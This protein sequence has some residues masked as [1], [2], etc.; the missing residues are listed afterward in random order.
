MRKLKLVFWGILVLTL[1][2]WLWA[3]FIS[4]PATSFF[5]RDP[6]LQVTGVLA[7]VCMSVTLALALR[8][9]WPERSLGGLDKMYRLHKWLGIG[10]LVFSLLHWLA[11]S[12]APRGPRGA[13]AGA[14]DASS[15]A[16][17]LRGL[18]D[19]AEGLGNPGLYGVVILIALALLRYFPY[20]WFYKTHRLIGIFYLLLVY[21][22]VVLLDFDDWSKPIG[23]IFALLLL[24]GSWAALVALVGKVGAGR[25]VNGTI[26]ELH[27]Y[28]GVESLEVAV[29]L[30]PGWPGHR[31]G[32]FLFAM[33]SKS[34]G[35]H[36]YTI[37]SPWYPGCTRLV[38]II[39]ALGDHTRRLPEI[40]KTGQAVR[41]EGPYGCFTFD[42]DRPYQIWIGGGI[43]ITPFIARMEHLSLRKDNPDWPA[44]QSIY[45]F[46]S[47]ADVDDEAL[48]KLSAD[49]QAAN[50]Q[51]HI[52][53]DDRDGRLSGAHIREVVPGW[54]D[55]SIW[56]CGPN[57]FGQA[58]RQD[59]AALGFD[60][61]RRFHQELFEMRLGFSR[62]M[63][64]LDRAIHNEMGRINQGPLRR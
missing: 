23:W 17:M 52:L 4:P 12:A 39:R 34:E 48:H 42:D 30:E 55:A 35:A 29:E 9:R 11:E 6:L 27:Y 5:T 24:A 57:G 10:A 63:A 25:Q 46:H 43:G 21:H 26:A 38:G 32:Q 60:V 7:M 8:P 2:L 28:P 22:T 62:V 15:L 59:F 64:R 3:K 13:G 58:I 14:V 61:E 20:R 56:F 45:L 19:G 33:S 1:A 44:G 47:T 49:A 31:P 54:K 18:R 40:L 37:A 16:G 50:I 41:V 36:P 51:L 53:V